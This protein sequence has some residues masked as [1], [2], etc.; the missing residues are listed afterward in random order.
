MAG[1]H[2]F[3]GRFADTRSL[4][5]VILKLAQLPSTAYEMEDWV[6]FEFLAAAFHLPLP[7][8]DNKPHQLCSSK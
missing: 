5:Q 1:A 6:A 2:S 4:N 8:T 7:V 3:S